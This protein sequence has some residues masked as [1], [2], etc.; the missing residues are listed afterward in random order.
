MNK[1]VEL[2]EVEGQEVTF[3]DFLEHLFSKAKQ[4]EPEVVNIAR[5]RDDAEEKYPHTYDTIVTVVAKIDDAK[6][7]GAELEAELKKKYGDKLNDDDAELFDILTHEEYGKF[8]TL[9]LAEFAFKE[10]INNL[11]S[12]LVED[13]VPIFDVVEV[14]NDDLCKCPACTLS[15]QLAEIAEY[16]N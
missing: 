8:A 9:N 5:F 6:K 12:S 7:T 1:D 13:K 10:V 3:K 15:K 11:V 16:G 2:R 4:D 14:P